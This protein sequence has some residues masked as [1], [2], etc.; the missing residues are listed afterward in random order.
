MVFSPK[1]NYYISLQTA[2]SL[3]IKLCAN[4][5]LLDLGNQ[6]LMDSLYFMWNGEDQWLCLF[7]TTCA[8]PTLLVLFKGPHWL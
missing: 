1:V 2:T 4:M 5:W 6:I 3:K 8:A 7:L